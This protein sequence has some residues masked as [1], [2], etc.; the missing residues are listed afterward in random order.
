MPHGVMIA[1][2]PFAHEPMADDEPD[3]DRLNREGR[4]DSRK[5]D[6]VTNIFNGL[7]RRDSR[8]AQFAMELS[9]A[10][11][12][13]VKAAQ[14]GDAEGLQRAYEAACHTKDRNNHGRLNE[15][16]E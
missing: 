1:I 12:Q 14:E 8:V 15:Y 9:R 4:F 13:M 7:K 16:D 3:E 11:R 6:V 2:S 10:L 5:R